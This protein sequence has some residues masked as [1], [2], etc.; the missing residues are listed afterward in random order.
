VSRAYRTLFLIALG[1]ALA[2][3]LAAR[4]PHPARRASVTAAA[5]VMVRSL[6][7]VVRD[8]AVT[9]DPSQARKGEHV[10]LTLRNDGATAVKVALAGYDARVHVDALAPGATWSAEFDADLPGEDFAWMVDGQP[11]GR[12]DVLGSHLV[13][14]HR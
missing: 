2:L 3:S 12:F 5:P 1:A 6:A 14:G 8:G 11:A 13:E 4:L 9:P 10:R 7:L